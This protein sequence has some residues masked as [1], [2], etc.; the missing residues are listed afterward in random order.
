MDDVFDISVGEDKRVEMV[1]MASEKI[2]NALQTVIPPFNHKK[3]VLRLGQYNR[4]GNGITLRY[5]IMRDA[6]LSDPENKG[7]R[8]RRAA[9]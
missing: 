7:L 8:T 1:K 4:D 6:R 9:S 5:E 3:D 2:R